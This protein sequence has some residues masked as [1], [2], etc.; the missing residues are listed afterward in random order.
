MNY[1]CYFLL[2]LFEFLLASIIFLGA[3]LLLSLEMVRVHVLQAST[4]ISNCLEIL[5]M[6]GRLTHF[7]NCGILLELPSR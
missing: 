6:L 3:L 7:M 4:W 1:I 2:P 5:Q